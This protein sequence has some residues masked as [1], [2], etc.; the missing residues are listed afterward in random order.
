[1]GFIEYRDPLVG[2]ISL[3]SIILLVWIINSA[4]SH[5]KKT[6][7][8][9][10]LER[11]VENFARVSADEDEFERLIT[12]F[13]NSAKM[14][15]VT[16]NGY[17]LSGDYE[18]AARFFTLI[19]KHTVR[20]DKDTNSK[21]ML[22]LARSFVKL[23]FLGRAKTVLIEL[24][25]LQPRNEPALKELIAISALS[26]DYSDP[27]GALEALTQ[28]DVKYNRCSKFFANMQSAKDGTLAD[29]L[30]TEPYFIRERAKIL[31]ANN[32]QDELLELAKESDSAKYL[33]DILW[34]AWPSVAQL[35]KVSDSKPL[36]ELFAAKGLIS[37]DNFDNF[38]LEL[39]SLVYEKNIAE[40]L[41][42][43][44]CS[45][46]GKEEL[47]YFP[48]CK[49]CMSLSTCEITP[50]IVKKST[51]PLYMESFS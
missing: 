19:L 21:I 22:S 48:I 25:R 16:A 10:Q 8:S 49:K 2:I 38:E 26:N 43:Y 50:K 29:N 24:L 35:Q 18:K 45:Q 4:L 7:K 32:K 5:Y 40:M 36:T 47:D 51:R 46:C 39:M 23:G 1:M 30:A 12:E 42:E 15:Y 20:T 13:P 41:F 14:L 17:F 6:Q 37:C 11:F 27:L 31:S 28:I 34:A 33:L 44:R 9:K 3:F